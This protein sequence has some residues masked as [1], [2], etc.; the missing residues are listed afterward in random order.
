MVVIVVM[1]VMWTCHVHVVHTRILKAKCDSAHWFSGTLSLCSK[2]EDRSQ[3]ETLKQERCARRDTWEMAKGIL[4]LKEKEKT[5]FFS[6]S[7]VWCLPAPSASSSPRNCSTNCS[8]C[9]CAF[10]TIFL[11]F[12]VPGM[13]HVLSEIF[14]RANYVLKT[15]K[16]MFVSRLLVQ[17]MSLYIGI[18]MYRSS[19]CSGRILLSAIF[20]WISRCNCSVVCPGKLSAR[21]RLVLRQCR[22]IH[23]I[24]EIS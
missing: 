23:D 8:A 10:H 14:L 21:T 9:W 2:F 13:T 24:H 19:I 22:P 16:H 20:L 15:S 18:K 7:D 3:E 1:L 12:L 5:K 17:P 11:Q 4:K 6:L